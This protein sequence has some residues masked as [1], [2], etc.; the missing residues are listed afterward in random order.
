[1][2]HCVAEYEGFY[3]LQVYLSPPGTGDFAYIALDVAGWPI[4]L[5]RYGLMAGV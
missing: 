2:I 5:G 4:E 3:R 1:M